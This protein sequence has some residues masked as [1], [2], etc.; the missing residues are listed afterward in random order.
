MV[1]PKI[2]NSPQERVRPIIAGGAG[3]LGIGAGGG[4]SGNRLFKGYSAGK[5]DLNGHCGH[6]RAVTYPDDPF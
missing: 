5:D 3:L 6:N 2:G 1:H 4:R